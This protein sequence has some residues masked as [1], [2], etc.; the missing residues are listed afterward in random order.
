MDRFGIFNFQLPG[1]SM[2][3]YLS[4]LVVNGAR[5]TCRRTRSGTPRATAR[6]S[7]SRTS[8]R[9]RTSATAPP[10]TSPAGNPRRGRRARFWR[11]EPVDPLHAFY[12][13]EVGQLTNKDPIQ[14]SGKIAFTAGATD[15]GM[16]FGYFNKADRMIALKGMDE[17]G[18]PLP[19]MMGFAIDGPTR[20]G[21]FFGTEFTP[22]GPHQCNH[23]QGPVFVPNR[24]PHD[25]TFAYDP[26]GNEGA[27]QIVFTL[28]GQTYK[29]NLTKEQQASGAQFTHF[30]LLNI[31]RGGKY[32]EVYLDD[33]QYTTRD[34]ARPSRADDHESA[35]SRR[36]RKY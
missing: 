8:T 21:Y 35:V 29:H 11:T 10:R 1:Q 4:D 12:A 31:R 9:S 13:V 26:S 22:E 19:N 18:A 20:I 27:G 33:L 3:F 24:K 15:A 30:G 28:D 6:S 16:F 34:R 32:V 7:S 36:G 17:S 25:F 14:F 2:E 23:G 5:S